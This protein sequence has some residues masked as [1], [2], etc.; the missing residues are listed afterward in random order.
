MS[1]SNLVPKMDTLKICQ[2]RNKEKLSSS[3]TFQ[4]SPVTVHSDFIQEDAACYFNLL[5]YFG[6]VRSP[7]LIISIFSASSTS[8]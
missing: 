2:R 7:V 1:V 6:E 5:L 4:L 8:W 3:E